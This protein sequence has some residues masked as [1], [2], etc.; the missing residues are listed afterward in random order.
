MKVMFHLSFRCQTAFGFVL[1][2]PLSVGKVGERGGIR[3]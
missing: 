1:K 2:V 3:G